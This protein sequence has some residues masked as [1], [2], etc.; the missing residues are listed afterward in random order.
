[1]ANRGA[2]VLYLSYDGMSDPLGR[3]QVLPYLTGLATRGHRITLMSFEKPERSAEERAA[4]ARICADAGISWGPLPYHKRPPLL[5]TLYDVREM[6][7][8]ATRLHKERN[9]DLVHCRSYLPALVGLRLKRKFGIPFIFDMRGFWAD[10]RLEAGAWKL[11]NPLFAAVYRYFKRRER[12]FWKE[13][14]HIVSLTHEGREV[15]AHARADG[16]SV[17]PVTVI[18]CC[19]EFDV[20][21]AINSARRAEARTRLGMPRDARVLAYIGSLGGNYMLAE[22]L[23]FFRAYRERDGKAIFLFVTHVPDD[24][25][26]NAATERGLA[27]D[28]IIIRG[29]QRDEVATVVAAADLGI[30]FK[31]PAFSAKACSPTKLGEMLAL[32]LPVVVNAGVG[33]VAQV[34]EEAGAGVVVS[35]FDEDAYRAA[36]DKLDSLEPEMARW[37][38]VSR[39]WFDLER[40]VDRYDAI[41]RTLAASRRSTLSPA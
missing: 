7:R 29:V 6:R 39:Q 41:Y 4:V 21:P 17:A 11:S 10:E 16:A 37:R 5:S 25:I 33:D 14:D 19:V 23:D 35:T 32:E 24:V 38:E 3:S 2:N 12:E 20:F 30:A 40:G 1:M 15:L 28:A 18:P 13:A 8:L 26:R 36:L 27:N 9:F 31:Q 34:V 22:M